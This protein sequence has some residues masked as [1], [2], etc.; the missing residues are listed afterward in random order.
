MAN[1][2]QLFR[3]GAGY[4]HIMRVLLALVAAQAAVSAA[5]F[6]LSPAVV[7]RGET[8]TIT[9]NAVGCPG[10]GV[11]F[12][13]NSI[14]ISGSGIVLAAETARVTDCSVAIQAQITTTAAIGKRD[15]LIYDKD[16]NTRLA[17][18]EIEVADILAGPIPPGLKPQVDVMYNILSENG[19]SD[20]LGN[21]IARFY[22]CVE[23]TLGNNSGYALLLAGVGFLRTMANPAFP[24]SS[25][26][27]LQVRSVLQR[28]QVISG[29][30]ITLRSLQAAGAVIA[31]FTPFSGNAGRRGR[32]GIWSS[33]A[34]NVLAGAYDGLIPDRTVRQL[35]NLDDAALRDGK[36]IPNNSPVKFTVFV[37]RESIVPLLAEPDCYQAYY[38]GETTREIARLNADLDVARATQAPQENIKALNA[39]VADLQLRLGRLEAAVKQ[40]ATGS[41]TD[42][43][44]C[45]AGKIPRT[46]K[47]L[48]FMLGR[49]R[50]P[51]EQDLIAVRRALGTLIIVG[52]QI[53]FKQRVRVDSNAVNPE[54]RPNPVVN[55]IENGEKAKQG[56]KVTLHLVGRFLSGATVT[57]TSCITTPIQSS[58]DVSGSRL[59][60]TDLTIPDTC[61][62]A[63]LHLTIST[64][65][66]AS[67]TFDVP[68]DP[69]KPTIKDPVQPA[70]VE[71]EEGKAQ[72]IPITVNGS[73]LAGAK[74]KLTINSA[75]ASKELDPQKVEVTST[76][77]TFEA[78][79]TADLV[80]G[81]TSIDLTIITRGGEVKKAAATKLTKKP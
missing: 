58:V 59:T 48:N 81:G 10:T 26:S 43:S 20:Q 73:G 2:D 15:V 75:G 29:R 61:T 56:D 51:R 55:G 32:I 64:G 72:N 31:G 16:H 12:D 38:R 17:A 49:S 57:T 37:D 45:E 69:M 41:K 42:L 67:T 60:L 14:E 3:G 8:T 19:C 63:V 9:L 76:K 52:D 44:S 18:L 54:V 71:V 79:L 36:L 24:E 39:A 21:R 74:V 7:Q 40:R 50:A 35:G 23:V 33:F 27:Y 4:R 66:S 22:Y 34:G 6:K 5:D 25:S 77:V 47:G 68:I 30:N 11:I 28:E 13:K 62:D 46:G 70:T 1:V 80:K 65:A 53:E 78:P